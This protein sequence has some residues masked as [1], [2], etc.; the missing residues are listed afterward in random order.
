[1]ITQV[2]RTNTMSKNTTTKNNEEIWDEL[3]EE[4]LD[5]VTIVIKQQS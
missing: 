2:K 5:K 3:W 4:I 1:M